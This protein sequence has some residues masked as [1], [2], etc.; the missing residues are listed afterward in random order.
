MGDGDE[1][2]GEVLP[3]YASDFWF[4]MWAPAGTPREIV[5]RLNH[6][7]VRILKQPDILERLRADLD[8]GRAPRRAGLA[9]VFGWVRPD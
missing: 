3:G 6:T 5:S 8:A 4:G 2:I 9:S 7:L 1:A